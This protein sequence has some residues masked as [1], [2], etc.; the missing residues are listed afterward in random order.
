MPR[1]AWSPVRWAGRRIRRY[2]VDRQSLVRDGSAGVTPV[3]QFTKALG[4]VSVTWASAE[5]NTAKLQE[6]YEAWPELRDTLATYVNQ[7]PSDN[8]Q[9]LGQEDEIAVGERRSSTP[10][11][12][13]PQAARP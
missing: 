11:P 3:I 10:S 12:D 6:R 1:M 8:V 4:P 5:E 13:D 9:R 7:H 2:A